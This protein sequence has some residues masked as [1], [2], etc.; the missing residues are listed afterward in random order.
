VKKELPGGFELDDDRARV[1]VDSVHEF[2]SKDA[3]WAL[4]RPRAE[5]ERLVRESQRVLGLYHGDKQIGFA[6]TVSDGASIAYLADVFVLPEWRGRGLGA[7]LVRASIDEGPYATTRWILHTKDM[8]DLYRAFGFGEPSE[9]L[10]ERPR[11]DDF[12]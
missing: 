1:D 3:Y 9:R 10:M 6:R 4:E 7:E 8:H 11:P 5:V 2:L 12:L